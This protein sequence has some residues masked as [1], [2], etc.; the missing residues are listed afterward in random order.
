MTVSVASGCLLAVTSVAQ[1][2]PSQMQHDHGIVEVAQGGGIF[3][4]EERRIITDVLDIAT[5]NTGSNDD[6]D[7]G[8]KKDKGN[9][10]KGNKGLPPGIAMKLERGGS[11]PPGIAKRDLP[12]D[13]TSRLPKRTDGAI[14]QIVG[15]DV[16]LIQKGT[17]VI[18]DII[19]GAA[20]N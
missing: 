7:K 6:G 5:G 20:K 13:L 19:R 2:H 14:R 11:L 17:E 3:S 18:L 9:K 10:G 16:V 8:G 4:D 1:A 15:E 12:S